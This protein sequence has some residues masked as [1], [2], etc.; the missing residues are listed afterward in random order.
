V[1]ENSPASEAGLQKNDILVSI[2]GKE[3]ADLQVSR[4]AE[5]FEK[6]GDVQAQDPARR[7]E[8]AN[9]SDAQKAD[10]IC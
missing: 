6:T 2:D 5:M 10:L 1:L 9:T 8:S 4:L 7:T 3:A